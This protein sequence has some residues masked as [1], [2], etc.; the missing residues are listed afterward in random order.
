MGIAIAR[1][2]AIL[3]STAYTTAPED[4]V[5]LIDSD[6]TI[7]GV[8]E[9]WV[10]LA[11]R[12]GARMERVG[13]GANYLD[14]CRRASSS[15][16]DAREAL[17]GIRAVLQ[18]KL[19]SFTMDYCAHAES[20]VRYFRMGVTP[21]NYGDAKLVVAHSDVTQLYLS[22]EKDLQRLQ[23]FA[24]G[25]I[26]AQ[27]QER[28][29][30][31]RE[32]HDDLGNRIAL[33]ACSVRQIQS[34]S[35]RRSG[36]HTKQLNAIIDNIANLSTALRSLSHWLHPPL[37][38][39]VG[40]LVALNALFREFETQ[41]L[42][43]ELDSPDHLPNFPEEIKLCI[44]RV[45]Q[46]CLNNIAKHAHASSVKV[47]LECTRKE[48]RLKIRDNGKGFVPSEATRGGL[49]LTS[50]TE[51]VLSVRGSLTI[52]S[53]PGAGAE[54]SVVIPLPKKMLWPG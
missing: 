23:G 16:P 35:P 13:P 5:A 33:L 18:G 10:L 41:G 9:K 2:F 34:Q 43:V 47:V 28:E 7:V 29:R 4:R 6:G 11:E 40:I 24:R 39:H 1:S 36:S 38:K 48:F 3:D 12:T 21:I 52:T 50:M 19:R 8:N 44:F 26:N 53:S 46:E 14:I 27:E 20:Q 37:L 22:K 32:I 15:T 25:L 31:A 54:I 42:E 49:G 45:S 51:R 30:I 17:S